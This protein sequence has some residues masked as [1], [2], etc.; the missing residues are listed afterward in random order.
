MAQHHGR[1]KKKK[2]CPHWSNTRRVTKNCAAPRRQR[3]NKKIEKE[4]RD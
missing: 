4:K 2:S 3:E 1:A